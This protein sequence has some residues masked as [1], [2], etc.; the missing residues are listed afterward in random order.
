M[1]TT[2]VEDGVSFDMDSDG[3]AEQTAWLKKGSGFLV[4][5]K[6]GDGMVND[7]TEMFGKA[8]VMSDGK[9]AENGERFGQRQ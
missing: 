2:S 1:L 3:M 5:D 6:N 7:G 4:W 8:T 9:R